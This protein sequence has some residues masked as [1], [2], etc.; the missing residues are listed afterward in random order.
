MDTALLLFRLL[1]AFVFVGYGVYSIVE[2]FFPSLREPD[3]NHWDIEIGRDDYVQVPG[4][5]K[6]F[7]PAR[8]IAEGYM[9]DSAACTI[10]A[11]A[12]L[13]LIIVGFAMIRHTAGIPEG[14]P[15]F[16]GRFLNS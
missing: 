8:V 12:G 11:L 15:D 5:R 2:I 4:W 9:S 6:V 3:F 1:P 14:V 10:S 13:F 7:K 16:I